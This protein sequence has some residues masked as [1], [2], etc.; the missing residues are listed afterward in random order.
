MKSIISRD[1]T[2]YVNP[3][4][5]I[6]GE[7]FKALILSS[8]NMNPGTQLRNGISA[9]DLGN[10]INIIKSLN[11]IQNNQNLIIMNI[12]SNNN[13]KT[14]TQI[15]VYDFDWGEPQGGELL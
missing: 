8:D 5:P 3:S 1:I 7:N 14:H 15:E 6:N 12:E 10:C 2:S 11:N 4:E 9:V 13:G